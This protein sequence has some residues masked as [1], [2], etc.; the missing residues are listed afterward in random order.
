[1]ASR[2]APARGIGLRNMAERIEHLG[3]N[4]RVLSTT[5]GTLIEAHVP[6]KHLLAPGQSSEPA[7]RESA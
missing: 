3:G 7:A 4:L 1:R 5:Q 2:Q 6:P